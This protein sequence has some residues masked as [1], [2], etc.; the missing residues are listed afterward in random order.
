VRDLVGYSSGA[1]IASC[2][3]KISRYH[4]DPEPENIVTDVTLGLEEVLWGDA[5]SLVT[6]PGGT[7][8]DARLTVT[9]TANFEVGRRYVVFFA[10]TTTDSVILAQ[11]GL[12]LQADEFFLDGDHISI[13]QLRNVASEAK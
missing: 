2:L 13:Q 11:A 9:H 6:I 10:K 4:G 5:I 7:V 8:G 12:C 1:A 3:S